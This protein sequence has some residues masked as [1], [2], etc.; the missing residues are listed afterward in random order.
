M[1]WYKKYITAKKCEAD[2]SAMGLYFTVGVSG[3]YRGGTYEHPPEYPESE[4]LDIEI[5][6]EDEFMIEFS[7]NIPGFWRIIE[8]EFNSQKSHF[9]Q[10]SEFIVILN[11]VKFFIKT[12]T[13]NFKDTQII[14][15]NI[16]NEKELIGN[17]PEWVIDKTEEA[18]ME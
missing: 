7:E 2:V 5:E 1:S 12:P 13:G 6:D 4:I 3:K 10:V 8:K 11:G 9:G 14:G 16:V 15:V 18:A 17:L